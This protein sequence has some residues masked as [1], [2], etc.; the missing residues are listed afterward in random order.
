[1]ERTLLTEIGGYR[2]VRPLG[3][4]GMGEV[5]EVVAQ[6]GRHYA[7]KEFTVDHGDIALLRKRF[8]VEA[9]LLTRLSHPRLVRVHDAGVD[10]TTQHPFF[11]MDL[12]L[13]GAGESMTLEAVRHAG[14]VTEELV[15]RWYHDLCAALDYCHAQGVVHR[16]VKLEN[17]LLDAD[18]HAV[19]SD[20]GVSRIVRPE[21]RSELQ[22]T[23]TFV[24]G[25]TTGTR[26]VIGTYWYLAPELRRGEAATASSDWYALGVA[27][28]RLLTGVWY[29]PGTAVLDLLAP[30][31]PV[32]RER[33]ERL[34]SDEP[35]AR[36]P[37]GQE[38][39]GR[40]KRKASLAAWLVVGV[41]AVGLAV[42][43]AVSLRGRGVSAASDGVAA[44]V[45][46]AE[47]TPRL[48]EEVRSPLTFELDATNRLAFC[49]CPP[50]TNELDGV[51]CVVSRP[52][53]LGSTPV[54]RR[55]WFAVLDRPLAAWRGGEDAPMTYVSREEV[56]NFCAILNA[57]F[58]AQLPAGYEIRLPTLAEWR[59]AYQVSRT[60]TTN[61]EDVQRLRSEACSV[62]WYGQDVRGVTEFANM[63]LYYLE[64]KLP[65]PLVKDI[66]PDFPPK[67][68]G[69][70]C[71]VWAR[72]SS[73][74]APVPVGLKPANGLGL[75]DMCGNCF[76]R[77]F[78][79]CSKSLYYWGLTEFGVTV[80][81]LYRG[82]GVIV[83][84]P[85]ECSGNQP[86]MVGTYLAPNLP[87][88]QVWSA[89]YDRLPHLGFRLCL[90]PVL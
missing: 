1:M 71:D 65:V 46:D 50:G 35:S 31:D 53:W 78:D 75:Y 84:G 70:A 3:K 11:V 23:T 66:W 26:P 62:G 36:I 55:Q 2:I 8:V 5:F 48:R 41:L 30:F 82:L 67:V 19:L 79:R 16:D 10:E 34:L 56:T 76:E 89:E 14:G 64:S 18:G 39:C 17:V 12:V 13:D 49:S 74:V 47:G 42:F 28:F 58:A 60:L 37:Y 22:V 80:T 40:R 9:R 27:I 4:G 61:P 83:D 68:I 87:G 20:F 32:W 29:E 44:V 73:E 15:E 52:Y 54:S 86:L 33:L 72:G 43:L 7:L 59:L 21:V 69:K 90:G 6:D 51:T 38:G 81:G 85:V 57:R 77:V 24:E 45:S 63:R 88:D 25:E